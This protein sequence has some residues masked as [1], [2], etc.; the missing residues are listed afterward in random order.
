MN[1]KDYLIFVLLQLFFFYLPD[2]FSDLKV[3]AFTEKI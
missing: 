3:K 2:Y 1:H